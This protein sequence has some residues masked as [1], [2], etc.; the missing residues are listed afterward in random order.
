MGLALNFTFYHVVGVILLVPAGVVAGIWCERVAQAYAWGL[1]MGGS[2]DAASM[3]TALWRATVGLVFGMG[4]VG[5][6]A[7]GQVVASGATMASMVL[8]PVTWLLLSL[9]HGHS[10]YFMA[11]ALAS[12]LL[13]MLALIDVRLQLLPDALTFPLLWLGLALAWAGYGI[14]LGDAVAGAIVGYGFLWLLFWLFKW[15]SGREGMG[16]GDFKLLAALG[17]WL[18]WRELVVVL[19]LACLAGMLFAM[20]RQKT[21]KPSG[22]YPFG[23]F[24]AA[25]GMVSLIVGSGV[26]LHFW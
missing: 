15:L 25:S 4:L 6:E 2:P 1:A 20:Y 5:T 26:H 23:P 14:S 21:L 18:G 13:L 10:L 9:L 3:R 8:M 16:Y 17:A 24:L 19:L 7:P 22:S 12:M 11:L